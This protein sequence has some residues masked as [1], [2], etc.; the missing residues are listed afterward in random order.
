MSVADPCDP[1]ADVEHVVTCVRKAGSR[2]GRKLIV[3]EA[4]RGTPDHSTPEGRGIAHRRALLC[5]R[6][7]EEGLDEV[8]L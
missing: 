2:E 1:I 7:R 4:L 8:F 6:L 3:F 5:T